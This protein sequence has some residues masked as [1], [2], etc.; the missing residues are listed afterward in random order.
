MKNI[1]II[2]FTILSLF[3]F[4]SCNNNENLLVVDEVIPTDLISEDSISNVLIVVFPAGKNGDLSFMNQ[5]A[6]LNLFY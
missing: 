4:F 1:L 2:S 5:I 3:L 6:R